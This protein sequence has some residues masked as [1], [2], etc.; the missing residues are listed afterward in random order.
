ML[1]D[2]RAAVGEAAAPL[3][4]AVP[5]SADQWETA[6]ADARL[7]SAVT[8]LTAGVPVLLSAANNPNGAKAA[9]KFLAASSDLADTLTSVLES[10]D[11]LSALEPA[12]H[13]VQ[14]LRHATLN[15]VSAAVAAA[16][17]DF[18]ETAVLQDAV[19]RTQAALAEVENAPGPFADDPVEDAFGVPLAQLRDDRD[20]F[21]PARLLGAYRGRYA[22][23]LE[24]MHTL[25]RA[26]TDDPPDLMNALHPAE[27]LVITSRPFLTVK[28]AIAVR[29][30][31]EQALADDPARVA[32][33]RELKL[34]V[35]RS[36]ASHAGIVA[37]G[38]AL[39]QTSDDAEYAR[40][41]LDLYCRM[42]EGQLRPWASALLSMRGRLAPPTLG[43]VREQLLAN[44]HPLFEEMATAILPV[45]RN[46]AAH[47]DYFW[48]DT[49]QTLWVGKE[50]VTVS[51][52]ED[53]TERAYS[54]MCGAECAWACARYASR[55]FARLLDAADPPGGIGPIDEST[56]LAHFGTNG[57]LPRGARLTQGTWTA[58]LDELPV[59]GI[60]P[61]FQALVWSAQILRG[62]RRFQVR[63]PDKDLPVIDIER[64]VLEANWAV[65]KLARATLEAMPQSTFLPANGW[66]RLAVEL[67]NEA[68]RAV[69]WL[70][71]N[72]AVDACDEMESRDDPTAVSDGETVRRLAAR[73]TLRL[74]VVVA[75]IGATLTVLPADDNQSLEEV[76]A[77]VE[78]AAHWAASAA[79]G[80]T[81]GPL[82]AYIQRMRQIYNAWPPVSVL[83][84][85]D[86][87]PLHQ[88]T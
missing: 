71:L 25:L 42:I 69:A 9:R 27:A 79:A 52:L 4:S 78:P 44:G 15:L 83:P 81:A 61:C 60:N 33:L 40:L 72:D 3:P 62:V 74:D 46:A 36:E 38:Q 12:A 55:R 34:R 5:V 49:A 23:L 53:A 13:R 31:I 82:P 76:L 87:T 17:R 63:L 51:A 45:A 7:P 57:L 50:S 22:E 26:I 48:D 11:L 66:T 2:A 68:S 64:R 28:A 43:A 59:Q 20:V 67:P 29:G 58:T 80:R 19:A 86:P 84:T 39:D 56:A 24:R 1:S 85:L 41:T 65:W 35:E 14:H 10:L 54:L 73:L 8:D 77:T 30:L 21:S 32:P 88:L 16:E 37:A 70:A 47:E 18:P 6:V 75:A